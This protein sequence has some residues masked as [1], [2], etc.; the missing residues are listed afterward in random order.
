MEARTRPCRF[1]HAFPKSPYCATT[2]I[3]EKGQHYAMV[4]AMLANVATRTSLR[5]TAMVSILQATFRSFSKPS[6]RLPTTSS[7]AIAFLPNFLRNKLPICRQQLGVPTDFP[8]SGYGCKQAFPWK[9]RRQDFAP[10]PC[11]TSTDW[12]FS[13][14]ATRRN[15]KSWCSRLGAAQDCDRFP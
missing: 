3:E 7:W 15:W 13:P 11:I 14:I 6:R 2:K 5:W 10:I 4:S 9:T 8:T 1:S 12:T